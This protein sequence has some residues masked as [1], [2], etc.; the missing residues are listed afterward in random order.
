M[1]CASEQVSAHLNGLCTLSTSRTPEPGL[2]KNGLH[3]I[4][5]NISHYTATGTPLFP[6]VLVTVPVMVPDPE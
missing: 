5:Q 1:I 2:K 3:N 6:I 4:M